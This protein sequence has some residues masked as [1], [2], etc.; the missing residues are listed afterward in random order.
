MQP[1]G[2]IAKHEARLA[3]LLLLPS[4]VIL[5]MIASYPLA[6]VFVNST[7]DKIFASGKPARFV[8]LKNYS[9]LLSMTIKELPSVID[10]NTGKPKIDLKTGEVLYQR[11]V[12]I[13]PREP[14]RYKEVSQFMFFG[15][16]YVIGAT[17]R[18]FI[19]AI[20]D[21]L[22]F[23]IVSIILE[24]MLGLIIALVL[25]SQ[26]KGRGGMRAVM[27]IPWAVPT[28]VSSRMWEWMFAST[29]AGFFNVF[30]Q[31]VG[32][33][34]GHISFLTKEAT[35][36]WVMVAIDVWKTTPFMALLLLA[37][38]QL[39]PKSIYESAYV[40]GANKWK[41]FWSMTL[42]M[43]RPTLVVAL[44]F[45]TLDALRVFDL[46]QIVLAQKRYSMASFTYYQLIDNQAMGYSSASSVIIFLLI[47]LF[48]LL[49]IKLVGG[50]GIDE[51]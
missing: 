4:F 50:V 45:R 18:D 8:G 27:L 47:L 17:D 34:D 29:R 23:T 41:Q 2:S 20:R 30:F 3:F 16:R 1:K 46:F 11:P 35:Q 40:D 38:L 43:L 48:T 31:W 12:K 21:T 28:A 22:T 19:R 7:T 6:M 42:P 33:G 51:S 15:K 26:F 39:I 10:E 14:M 25:N 5:V 44:V 36:L 13:L 24:T 49:Y 32:L 37:G 9:K